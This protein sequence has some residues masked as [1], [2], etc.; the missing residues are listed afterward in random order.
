M[1]KPKDALRI[2]KLRIGL[3]ETS[4]DGE[5]GASACRLVMCWFCAVVGQWRDVT[6][7]PGTAGHVESR[8]WTWLVLFEDPGQFVRKGRRLLKD[9]SERANIFL[10]ASGG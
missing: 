4:D 1:I 8:R 7:V 2:R 5:R 3:G 9:R 10:D 6:D